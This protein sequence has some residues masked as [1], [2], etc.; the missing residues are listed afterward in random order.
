MTIVSLHPDRPIDSETAG[1]ALAIAGQA[2]LAIDNAR[3]YGQQKAFADT[4]Q[5]SLLPRTAPEVAELE[6]GDVYESRCAEVGGDVYDYLTLG[7]GRL[8]VVLGDVTGHGVDAAADM[9]MAKYVFRAAGA[10]ARRRASSWRQPTTSSPPTSA[11]PVHPPWSSS[12]STAEGEVACA[13]GGH[14][15]PWLVL[16]DGRVEEIAQAASRWASRAA[17][18]ET[19][20]APFPA[21]ATVVAYT[22]GSSRRGGRASSSGRAARCTLRGAPL[23]SLP[24]DAEAAPAACRAWIGRR[25]A[26]GR[27]RRSDRWSNPVMVSHRG[28]AALVF[29]AGTGVL[30]TEI[31]APRLLAPYFGSST[32]VWANPIGIVLAGLA[33]GYGLAAASPTGAP[34]RSSSAGS[35]SGPRSGSRSRPSS[36]V[37]SWTQRSEAST[38]RRPAR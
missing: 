14:P 37:R 4:M 36:H 18:R 8:A 30:A 13:S 11:R 21:G 23:L 31:A 26:E 2:A 20:T 9:A 35:C 29:G 25:R 12:C 19:V 3:L 32:I 24:R 16:P 27:F 7:D 1:T 10:R 15:L 5:R 28:L 34:S 22:D 17:A 33:A 38:T 6:L